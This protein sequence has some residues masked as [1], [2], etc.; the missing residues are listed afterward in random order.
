MK[1]TS[2]KKLVLLGIAGTPNDFLLSLPLLKSYLLG[3]TNLAN[4]LKIRLEQHPHIASDQLEVHTGK[5]AGILAEER[6]DFLGF[7]CYVWNMEAVRRIIKSL[8]ARGV[9]AKIILGGPEITRD[10]IDSGSLDAIWADYLILGEGEKPLRNLMEGLLGLKAWRPGE[11]KSLAH[12][13][14]E[15][16]HCNDTPDLVTN[17][18]ALPSP[19]LQGLIPDE[20]LSRPGIRVNVET[21]RG[22]NFR[23]AYCYYHKNFPKIRYKDEAVVL[24]EIEFAYRKGIKLGR[25]TDAN[26]LSDRAYAM[27]ILGGLIERGIKMSLFFELLPQFLDEELA[28]LLGA[29]RQISP[30]NRYTV[31]IGLQT[32]TQESLKVIRRR[33]AL[34]HFEKAF[35]LLQESGVI[36]KSDIIL[37]LPRETKASY[38]RTLE[39]ITE[40]MRRGSNYLS[41]AV[42]RLL[43][44]TELVDIA[45]E[46]GLVIDRRDGAHWVYETPTMPRRDMLECLRMNA[47][48]FRLLSSIDLDSR[49]TLRDRYFETKDSLGLSNVELL[50]YFAGAFSIFLA[51][52]EV[53]FVTPDFPNAEYYYCGNIHS[54]IPD[55][56]LLERLAYL[57]RTGDLVNNR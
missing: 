26:F 5:I 21:Q 34:S 9:P 10:A 2:E 31:G 3:C 17:L 37:G 42:L 39:F 45:R 27:K 57:K 50:S 20:V 55:A 32:L 7:S 33:I 13:Q 19:F 1:V 40:K 48:A 35:E 38:F 15:R 52:K 47:A 23:C 8:K 43:P 28:G 4:N 11:I 46:E 16:F 6:A 44:G 56:W 12:V 25:I 49:I 54:D 41:L 53:D 51:G 14:G 36:I 24:D 30:D 18:R 22:C 29:Y